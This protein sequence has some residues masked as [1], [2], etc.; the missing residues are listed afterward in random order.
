MTLFSIA[1]FLI[2]NFPEIFHIL[3]GIP[4]SAGRMGGV[5]AGQGLLCS[6][7][8]SALIQWQIFVFP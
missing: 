8:N 6:L 3:L 2:S 4:L 5:G 7:V 1:F